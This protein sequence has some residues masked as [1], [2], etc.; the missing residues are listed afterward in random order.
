MVSHAAW[1]LHK[2]PSYEAVQLHVHLCQRCSSPKWK[3]MQTEHRNMVMNNRKEIM[4]VNQETFALISV[5]NW[6]INVWFPALLELLY[7]LWFTLKLTM[8]ALQLCAYYD[9]WNI[10]AGNSNRPKVHTFFT[11]HFFPAV[12][13]C[14]NE[15]NYPTTKITF[16]TT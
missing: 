5:I 6:L 11:N 2:Q 10:L 15:I 4:M 1:A 13:L 8:S 12:A 16:Y 14:L 7:F 9:S 3:S